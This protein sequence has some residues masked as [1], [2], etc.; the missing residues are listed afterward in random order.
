MRVGTVLIPFLPSH[1]ALG[2][3]GQW[4][5]DMER[6]IVW[7]VST[8]PSFP[9]GSRH[10][11]WYSLGC[12]H[13]V[14][15]F[16]WYTGLDGADMGGGTGRDVPTLSLASHGT[17]GWDG[18]TLGC[19]HEWWY[20]LGCSHS[21]AGTLGYMMGCMMECDGMNSRYSEWDRAGPNGHEHPV[22]RVQCNGIPK[23]C[24][25]SVGNAR[26][27]CVQTNRAKEG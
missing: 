27:V 22:I 15:S 26:H 13:S 19:R 11:G 1:G 3:D 2:W 24:W 21:V 18:W 12:S 20:S 23:Y 14:P 5:A 4:D 17:L 25:M 6:G 8:V 10:G 7:D 9:W 16:P